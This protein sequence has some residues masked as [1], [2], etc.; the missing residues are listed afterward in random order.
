MLICNLDA[1][2]VKLFN[3]LSLFTSLKSITRSLT[4]TKII[5]RVLRATLIQHNAVFRPVDLARFGTDV[6]CGQTYHVTFSLLNNYTDISL[7][8]VVKTGMKVFVRDF[9]GDIPSR[10]N[11]AHLVIDFSLRRIRSVHEAN[12]PGVTH[13]VEK[14]GVVSIFG[15][16]ASSESRCRMFFGVLPKMYD[17]IR[18]TKLCRGPKARCGF[19]GRDVAWYNP[20]HTNSKDFVDI[21]VKTFVSEC[22]YWD[23]QE[24]LWTNRGCKVS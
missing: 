22:L 7:L 13:V 18:C 2:S 8:L 19:C 12:D 11:S 9:F 1:V 24:E 21:K 16:M 3:T 15:L 23:K 17:D 14:K 5:D 10:S 20:T 4:G 6:S